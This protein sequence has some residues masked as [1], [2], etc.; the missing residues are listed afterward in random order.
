MARLLHGFVRRFLDPPRPRAEVHRDGVSVPRG[1]HADD[2]AAGEPRR[3]PQ[4]L[5]Q[6]AHGS[7]HG[8]GADHHARRDAGAGDRRRSHRGAVGAVPAGGPKTG[9]SACAFTRTR[10]C[11][12]SCSSAST[13]SISDRRGIRGR[14]S[15]F[16]PQRRDGPLH[17][18]AILLLVTLVELGIWPPL[19][20]RGPGPVAIEP[21]AVHL[22]G[23]A[24]NLLRADLPGGRGDP[25]GIDGGLGAPPVLLLPVGREPRRSPWRRC[26]RDRFRARRSTPRPWSP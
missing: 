10:S 6:R 9:I 13:P 5:V 24:L 15:V 4:P 14:L 11:T 25:D 21:R 22:P 12:R 18:D 19:L 23:D 20:R 7:R 16:T 2:G 17:H 8:G 26:P 1:A 3:Y